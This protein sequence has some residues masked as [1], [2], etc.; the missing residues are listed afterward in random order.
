MGPTYF[1]N[2]KALVLSVKALYVLLSVMNT[3]LKK[4]KRNNMINVEDGICEYRKVHIWH[5]DMTLN[6]LNQTMS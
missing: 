2:G 4:L 1:N 6:K 5:K 3:V